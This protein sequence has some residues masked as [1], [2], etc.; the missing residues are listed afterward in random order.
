MYEVPIKTTDLNVPQQSSAIYHT[1]GETPQPYEA[2]SITRRTGNNGDNAY[3][4]L[5]PVGG[6]AG[7]QTNHIYHTVEGTKV[8]ITSFYIK[9]VSVIVGGGGGHF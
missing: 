9:N 1:V 8:C 7:Q 3:H 4:V 6:S 2:P 5:E